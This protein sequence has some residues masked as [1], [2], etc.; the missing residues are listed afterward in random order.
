MTAIRLHDTMARETPAFE[1]ADPKRVTMYVCGPT[2]YSRAH[3]GNTRPA[4]VFDVLARLLRNRYGEARLVYAPN[5]TE[6][7]DKIIAAA[8]ADGVDPTFTNAR[9]KAFS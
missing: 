3:I 8:K 4:G 1:P 9:E 5:V 6:V 2:V 7:Y